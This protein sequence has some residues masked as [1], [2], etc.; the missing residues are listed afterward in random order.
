MKATTSGWEVA[1]FEANEG[2]LRCE[3]HEHLLE[4]DYGEPVTL[5]DVELSI[6]DLE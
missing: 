3:E 2:L 1:E 5:D 4:G 6:D